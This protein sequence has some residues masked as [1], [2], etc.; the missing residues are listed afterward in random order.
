MP[1]KKDRHKL[2]KWEAAK[3]AALPGNPKFRWNVWAEYHVPEGIQR[4]VFMTIK[5]HLRANAH[6]GGNAS[7]DYV[8]NKFWKDEPHPPQRRQQRLGA[9][10]SRINVKLRPLGFVIK[11]GTEKRTYLFRRLRLGE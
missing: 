7:I 4:D 9:V 10:I 5:D 2:A 11:P 3:A 1:S 6:R 8:Y